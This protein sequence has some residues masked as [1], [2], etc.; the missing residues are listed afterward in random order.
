MFGYDRVCLCSYM[1]VQVVCIGVHRHTCSH[2]PALYV[3]V[4][5]A[6]IHECSH[7]FV[8]MCAGERVLANECRQKAKPTVYGIPLKFLPLCLDGGSLRKAKHKDSQ[9]ALR[10]WA[11]V[12]CFLSP[13]IL[14][15]D[16]PVTPWC[17]TSL[18]SRLIRSAGVCSSRDPSS[19]SHTSSHMEF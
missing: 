15:Q 4:Y 16:S 9:E 10:K 14:N 12:Q 6:C 17:Y 11:K 19:S 18:L 3:C 2:V 13:C 7:A 8:R 1:C 5:F